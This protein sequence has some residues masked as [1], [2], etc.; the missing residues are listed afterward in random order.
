MYLSITK[1]PRNTKDLTYKM[2]FPL[3][4]TYAYFQPPHLPFTPQ[5]S[6]IWL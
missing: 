5:P 4:S 6:G 2:S 1:E 3:N